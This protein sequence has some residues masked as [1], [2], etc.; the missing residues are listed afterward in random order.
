MGANCL[1]DHEA[2]E[3]VVATDSSRSS[4]VDFSNFDIGAEACDIASVSLLINF[5]W[6]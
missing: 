4:D 5:A 1:P 3:H 6:L 2:Y